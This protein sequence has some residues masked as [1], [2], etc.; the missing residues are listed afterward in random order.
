MTFVETSSSLQVLY[1]FSFL[2]ALLTCILD[3]L[4]CAFLIFSN[5]TLSVS[6]KVSFLGFAV[7]VIESI[8]S[9]Y[10]QPLFLRTVQTGVGRFVADKEATR[11]M[12]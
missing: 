1:R 7:S 3:S 10:V 11:Q 4:T 8:F 5:T 6:V 9:L 2:Y 12:L